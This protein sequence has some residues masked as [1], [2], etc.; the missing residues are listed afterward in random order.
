MERKPVPLP[1]RSL[2]QKQISPAIDING[3]TPEKLTNDLSGENINKNNN[4]EED[5]VLPIQSN[6]HNNTNNIIVHEIPPPIPPRHQSRAN[7]EKED[8]FASGHSFASAHSIESMTSSSRTIENPDYMSLKDYQ[9]IAINTHNQLS[10]MDSSSSANS[11]SSSNSSKTTSSI[12]SSALTPVLS[13]PKLDKS[14]GWRQSI[15]VNPLEGT[16]DLYDGENISFY[17]WV[18]LKNKK[19]F[20]QLWAAIQKGNI[21]FYENEDCENISFGPFR[22]SQASFIGK[23]LTLPN[24]INLQIRGNEKHVTWSILEFTCDEEQFETWIH[25]LARSI[26]P[27]G[28]HFKEVLPELD[29]GGLLW[30]KE[31]TTSSYSQCWAYIF[32]RSLYYIRLNKD[33]HANL[34]IRKIVC[35]KKDD[36]KANRCEFIYNTSTTTIVC[37]QSGSTLYLQGDTDTCTDQWF[38]NLDKELKNVGNSLENQRLTQDN[39]PF[40]VDKC[41]KYISTYGRDIP[42]IYRK[43]GAASETRLIAHGLKADP[44]NYH[45]VKKT[46]ETV[47]A[48]ADAL[49]GFFRQLNLPVISPDLHEQ[50]YNIIESSEVRVD[51]ESKLEAYKC[52]LNELPHIN[53]CTLKSLVCHL[54]EITTH[55]PIN[56]ASIENISKIFAPTLFVV[57]S[58]D[59]KLGSHTFQNTSLQMMI[60]KELLTHYKIIFSVSDEEDKKSSKI[61]KAQAFI[62]D[63]GKKVA[64]GFL[65]PIHLYEFNN[66]CFNVKA[67]WK[68]AQVCSYASGKAQVQAAAVPYD[69]FEVIKGGTLKRRIRSD[70][71]L[72]SIVAKRWIDWDYNDCFLLYCRDLHPLSISDCKLMVDEV[73]IAEPGSRSFKVGHIKIESVG[74]S[75]TVQI[76][77]RSKKLLTSLKLKDVLWFEGHEA[78]RKP[79]YYH[80]ITFFEPSTKLKYKSKFIGYCISFKE[81]INKLQWLTEINVSLNEKT[82]VD[83]LNFNFNEELN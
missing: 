7:L 80:N 69:L 23:H 72:K 55:A 4:V 20:K 28:A 52:I 47:F 49:R 16:P 33:E 65:V 66:Q 26:I 19:K 29:V 79:S 56:L 9:A 2:L 3:V 31:G 68:A 22:L 36:S 32:K 45:I 44:P 38:D 50:L 73:K 17:S 57:D 70:E 54:H 5:I 78:D 13:Y 34:D 21:Y 81:E 64:V 61:D 18:S 76:S 71:C 24:G 77:N 46:D 1:R 25:L 83:L 11:T 14:L 37:S 6:V 41:L 30:I 42:G 40:I 8:S 75:L 12:S 10:P 63:A 60:V 59:E 53:Y 51:L 67:D 15:K 39:L 62:N 43:N 35:L 27:S 74:G 58:V 82:E 48:V